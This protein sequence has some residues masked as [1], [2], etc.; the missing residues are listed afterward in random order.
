[1]FY[2]SLQ[3]SLHKMFLHFMEMVLTFYARSSMSSWSHGWHCC[4]FFNVA[5]VSWLT[6]QTEETVTSD[7]HHILIRLSPNI[8][9]CL[10]TF[11]LFYGRRNTTILADENNLQLVYWTWST[12]YSDFNKMLNNFLSH[13]YIGGSSHFN[14]TL[15]QNKPPP[16]KCFYILGNC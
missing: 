7:V 13:C 1:M 6:L 2:G 4:T 9:R 5:M 8:S 10:Q 11:I 3:R 15:T 14:R 12:C 16:I